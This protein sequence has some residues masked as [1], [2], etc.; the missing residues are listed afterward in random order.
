MSLVK[1]M[2]FIPISVATGNTGLLF[3]ISDN[4]RRLSK[5]FQDTQS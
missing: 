3:A 1:H 2:R 4:R 5:G